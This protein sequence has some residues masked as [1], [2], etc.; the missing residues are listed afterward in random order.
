MIGLALEAV[1]N[2]GEDNGCV[3]GG[4]VNLLE[5]MGVLANDSLL[6]VEVGCAQGRPSI[7][8]TS[9][10]GAIL[11]L[12]CRPCLKGV[13]GHGAMDGNRDGWQ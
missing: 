6:E 2:S 12:V 8:D 4:H 7:E 11:F 3:L 5:D 9:E 10:I 1:K 13:V